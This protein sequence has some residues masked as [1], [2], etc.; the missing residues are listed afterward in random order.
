M[1]AEVY[2]AEESEWTFLLLKFCNLVKGRFFGLLFYLKTWMFYSWANSMY[3]G[4]KS[5]E[6]NSLIKTWIPVG[7]Q[8]LSQSYMY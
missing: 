3:K 5:S 6:I 4:S 1:R 8:Q 2:K 7:R